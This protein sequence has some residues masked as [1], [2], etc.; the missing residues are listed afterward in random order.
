MKT[1]NGSTYRSNA[2]FSQ[3]A[4][5]VHRLLTSKGFVAPIDLFATL[6]LVELAN[7]QK[8]RA[9]NIDYFE[10]IVTCNLSK[11]SQI[12]RVLRF[13]ALALGLRPSKSAYVVK[14]TKRPLQFSKSGN[15]TIESAYATHYVGLPSKAKE[16]SA[17]ANAV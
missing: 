12:M 9:G 10:R 14:A 16:P 1:V 13:H 4:S 15:P 2:Y 17:N 8:W 7:V 11:A 5:G 6:D 3:V